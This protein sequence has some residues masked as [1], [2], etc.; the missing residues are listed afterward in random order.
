MSMSYD[1]PLP[2]GW[3]EMF[4]NEVGMPYFVDHNTQTTTWIDPRDRE[5]KAPSFAAC[6]EGELPY[7]W[8]EAR[9][10]L[11]GLYYIDHNTWTTHLPEEMS[12]YFAQQKKQM[13]RLLNRY[14]KSL[15]VR[16]EDVQR[17]RAHIKAT[18]EQLRM[19]MD[20]ER[21]RSRSMSVYHIRSGIA[22]TKARLEAL[23]DELNRAELEV[24]GRQRRV[25]ILQ[26]EYSEL[27]AASK[28]FYDHVDFAE[29]RIREVE[30]LEELAERHR[31]Q[32]I[33]LQERQAAHMEHFRQL[34][35]ISSAD[36]EAELLT[37]QLEYASLQRRQLEEQEQLQRLLNIE[38]QDAENKRKVDMESRHKK[39]QEAQQ[40]AAHARN[41]VD[42]VIVIGGSEEG[43]G[44]HA[45]ATQ[46][47]VRDMRVRNT[48]FFFVRVCFL[49]W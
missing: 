23:R 34:P 29:Q 1:I 17:H 37:Q 3:E 9:H 20:R 44:L 5:T 43:A 38:R 31:L 46:S 28:P 22:E 24:K 16:Q 36:I 8:A 41:S 49:R 32:R 6:D 7:G 19:L 10:P 25:D 11:L 48:H 42:E 33:S 15:S 13:S 2:D 39:Q 30:R 45:V 26:E 4:D 18:E 14:Q 35:D 27:N 12:T 21:D 40:R 47:M